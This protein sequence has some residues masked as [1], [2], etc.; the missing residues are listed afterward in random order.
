MM[1]SEAPPKAAVLYVD[2]DLENLQSFKAVFRRDYDVHLAHTAQEALA[3]LEQVNFHVLITDQRMPEMS[4]S[5]LLTTVADRFPNMLR[6]ILTGFSDFDPMVNALNEGRLQGYFSKPLDVPAMRKRI[7]DGLAKYYLK[8]KN[9]EL[10]ASLR[11]R[12][13][14]IR[15]QLAELE[16]VYAAAPVGLILVDGDYRIVRVNATLAEMDGC[17]VEDHL[18]RTLDE[19]VP[20]LADRLKPIYQRVIEQGESVINT[21]IH[22]I[23]PKAPGVE[24]DWLCSYYP[25]RNDAG[26]I[27]GVIGGVI[28][29]TELKQAEERAQR[30]SQFAQDLLQTANA[31]IVVLDKQGCVRLVNPMVEQVTGY[32]PAELIGKNWFEA[33]VPR[34]IYPQVWSEFNRLI[35]GGFPRLFENPIRTK[36]GE[37]IIISWSNTELE[38][39]GA[40]VGTLSVGIDITKRRAAENEKDRLAEQLRQAQKMEAI[41]TLAGGIAH[42]F[43]NIL[44]PIIG[45]AEIIMYESEPDSDNSKSA[46]E[47]LTA[48][49]RARDLVNQILTFSREQ[50]Q[51]KKPIKVQPVIKEALKLLRASLPTTIELNQRI[52]GDCGPILGDPTQIYQVVMN[53]CTNAYQAMQDQGGQIEVTASETLVTDDDLPQFMDIAPGPYVRVSVSDTGPGVEPEILERIFDPYFTTKRMKSGTGLGLSVVHG[54]VKGHAGAI[55]VYSETGQGTSF[56]VYLPRLL[57]RKAQVEIDA[58]AAIVGGTEAILLVDDEEAIVDVTQRILKNLGYRVTGMTD[59]REALAAFKASPGVFD[60]IISDLTMPHLSG[61]ELAKAILAQ[62]PGVPIVICTGFSEMINRIQLSEIGIHSVVT[63]PIL[64]DELAKTIRKVLDNR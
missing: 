22:G 14:Q 61:L 47:I 11:E 8:L 55:N 23:T 13:Q 51:K 38:E 33:V 59:G 50:E 20:E 7:E 3:L 27:I 48:G 49:M 17:T 6:F 41:G 34:D 36:N 1:N 30:A 10:N 52:E 64:K 2:D 42:D 21:A 16:Q 31:L 58:D 28:E 60:L 46:E 12:E 19:V 53:L 5:D 63:K 26:D 40:L 56:S 45:Y 62:R 25:F 18:G 35:D 9:D 57:D 43:N 54:I 37:E 15:M 4:G 39:N 29:V 44:S 24:R 32:P